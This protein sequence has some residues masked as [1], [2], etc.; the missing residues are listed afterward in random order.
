VQQTV[1]QNGK[2]ETGNGKQEMKNGEEST[3]QMKGDDI[4]ARCVALA[5][6]V[7]KIVDALPDTLAQRGSSAAIR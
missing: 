2:P 1:K 4:A 7:V 5:V 6:R 3:V